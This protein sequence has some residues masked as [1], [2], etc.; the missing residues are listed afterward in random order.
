MIFINILNQ[1]NSRAFNLLNK[2]NIVI[3]SKKI[4]EE[5]SPDIDKLTHLKEALEKLKEAQTVEGQK[6]KWKIIY[7]RTRFQNK[8]S[9]FHIKNR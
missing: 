4:K 1:K 3:F 2:L 8:M 6:K 9:S 7:K 5:I